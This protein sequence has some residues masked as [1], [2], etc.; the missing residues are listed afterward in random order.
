M[1]SSRGELM[2]EGRAVISIAAVPNLS[3]PA[4]TDRRV[5][6]CGWSEF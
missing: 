1:A 3:L 6:G 5:L 4:T 2:T